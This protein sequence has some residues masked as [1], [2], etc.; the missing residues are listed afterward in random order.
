MVDLR[1]KNGCGMNTFKE[2][3]AATHEGVAQ[4][5]E[6]APSCISFIK[7]SAGLHFPL[8]WGTEMAPSAIHCS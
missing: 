6:V 4:A 2:I 8:T 3:E 1:G 7:I 5:T